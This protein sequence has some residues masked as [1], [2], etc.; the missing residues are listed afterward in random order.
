MLKCESRGNKDSTVFWR[1]FWMQLCVF[2][3]IY[4]FKIRAKFPIFFFT[5]KCLN[6]TYHSNFIRMGAHRQIWI[7]SKTRVKMINFSGAIRAHILC[8]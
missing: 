8:M 3:S 7:F 4:I 5:K 1:E 6:A 2:Y